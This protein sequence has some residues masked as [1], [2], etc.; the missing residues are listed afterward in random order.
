MK[1][2]GLIFLT[3]MLLTVPFCVQAEGD[4]TFDLSEI[5]KKP[6]QFSGYVEARP[7]L[8]GLDS[9][10]AFYKLRFYDDSHRHAL[11]ETNGRVRLEGS[12][13]KSFFR[14]FARLNTDL[15][16]NDHT[17]G[18]EK[19]TFYEAY[20]SAKPLT[21]VKIDAGKKTLKWGKG[22]AWNPVAFADRPKDPDDPEQAMEGYIVAT[23]DFIRSFGGPLKTLSFT[24]V[25]FPVYEH[26]NSDFGNTNHLNVAGRLYFLFYDTD[27]DLVFMTG[28]S[29]PDRYGFDFSRNLT[30]NFEIHGEYAWI[31]NHR[32]TVLDQSG[33]ARQV[34][35]GAHSIL[36]GL[37]YLT[38][39]DL[40]TIIEFYHN[41]A[42]FSRD[43][44]KNF[45]SLISSGFDAY[46]TSGDLT[47]LG[48]A[49]QLAESGYARPNAMRNY[50]Y[51]RLSQKEPFDILY[52]T[53][54]LTCMI[55]MDDLSASI[56]PELL[57]TGITNLELRL[58]AS[59][60]TG[61]GDSE[62][63]EKQNDYRIELR[64]GYYF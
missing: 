35:G 31:T 60:I 9:N 54:S 63:G 51:V 38:S 2:F 52:F 37:R 62:F 16:Y 59:F 13:E 34:E 39:F 40:T 45:Y 18:S 58:R 46:Q 3:L 55:N 6:Y 15:Q 53:P 47:G 29:R 1:R 20:A 36:V 57:Y 4:Y 7:V 8:Y 23:A 32:K 50:L 19:T 26:I 10:A 48:R 28:G 56:I 43:E 11:V 21:S 61:A 12:Y 24:P 33:A 5:E 41:S 64:I 25:L 22:Y 17:H 27:I 30:T 14:I 49:M 42:G 44:M